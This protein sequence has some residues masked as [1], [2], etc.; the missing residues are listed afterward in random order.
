MTSFGERFVRPRPA[1]LGKRSHERRDLHQKIE[2]VEPNRAAVTVV[3]DRDL[4][5]LELDV[6]AEASTK[7]PSAIIDH[8]REK[9]ARFGNELLNS[10]HSLSLA[11]PPKR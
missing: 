7:G 9:L 2:M 5:R 3:I 8:V 1:T 6:A 4:G 11:L 10:A